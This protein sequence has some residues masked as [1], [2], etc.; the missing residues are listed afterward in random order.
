MSHFENVLGAYQEKN[1]STEIIQNCVCNIE[2]IPA[3]A[4]EMAAKL[5]PG[6]WLLL[7]ADLGA[8]KTTLV[9]EICLSLG[10]KEESGSPTFSI[11]NV[12]NLP[13][14]SES[15]IEKIIHIDLYRIA[16]GAE[17]P[18]LGIENEF[19]P[20]STLLIM[21]WPYQVDEDDWD[22]FFTLTACLSHLFLCFSA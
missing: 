21:E 22:D 19:L 13:I 1:T 3:L 8:G 17:L 10:S 14:P 7:D 9:N 16:R 5:L 15:G 11:S 6:T 20:A 18:F 2:D 12:L 4:K